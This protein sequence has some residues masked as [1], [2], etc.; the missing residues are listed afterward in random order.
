M[1]IDTRIVNSV[2]K[3]IECID[4][5]GNNILGK[6]PVF[7]FRGVNSMNHSLV[8]SL[9]RSD[10]RVKRDRHTG[11]YSSMHYAEDIR[12]YHYIAKNYHFFQKEPSSRVEWLE[13][14]QHHEMKTRVLDWSES[15]IHSLIFALEPFLDDSRNQSQKRTESVP[16]VWVLEPG[17]LNSKIVRHLV[18]NLFHRPDFIR[19][20]L[21]ELELSFKQENHIMESMKILSDKLYNETKDTSH[22]DYIF[23]LSVINDEILRD[24]QRLCYLLTRGDII[25]PFYYLLSRIYSDGHILKER[26]L[27]PLAVV[28]P[29]HSE[30]IK[31]QKGVFTVFPFYEEKS[32]D[33][34]ARN[35]GLNPDAL[36]N[37]LMAEE[38]LHKIIINNP[39]KVAA[40][41]LVNGM[42]DSWLYPEM[43]IVA[44]EIENHKVYS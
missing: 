1:R 17:K 31:A 26:T 5:L 40:E 27:A 16:C 35:M 15:S 28:H 41:L 37:I 32:D 22:I 11:D 34:T 20:L 30:R 23:D 21:G 4:G 7:W 6:P 2:G 9:F 24:R 36:E 14:M 29:Y 3:Y 38:C 8:P 13:V 19:E 33:E 44:S 10:V 43:P 39:Q 12:A 42:N 25:N 18:F